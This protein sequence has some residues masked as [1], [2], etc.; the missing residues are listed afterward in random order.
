MRI[1]SYI[2]IILIIILGLT[3]AV[4][5]AGTVALNYYFGVVHISLSLLLVMALGLGVLLG[6]LA[7]LAPIFRL[8]RK[9]SKLSHRVKEAEEE[10]ENLRSIP[11]NDSH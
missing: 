8:K 2:L 9:N 7:S 10:I 1:V 4:L 5:N 3:F 6:L 11:I